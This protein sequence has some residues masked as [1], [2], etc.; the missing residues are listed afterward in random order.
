MTDLSPASLTEDLDLFGPLLLA[1]IERHE[2]RPTAD[3]VRRVR[4][5]SAA[6]GDDDGARAEL[7]D[8]LRA[9]ELD[10]VTVLA[11]ALR[12]FF[13]LANVTE[14]AHRGSDATRSVL[15]DCVDRVVAQVD[16]EIDVRRTAGDLAWRPVL[17]AHPTE[18]SRRTVLTKLRLVAELMARRDAGPATTDDRRLAELVDVL[19]QTDG[20]RIGR[21]GPVDEARTAIYYLDEILVP[22]LVAVADA[23][24]ELLRERGVTVPP[25]TAPI[26]FGTWVGGDRDGNPYVTPEVTETVVRLQS[27]RALVLLIDAV[28]GLSRHLSV[29]SRLAGVSDALQRSLADDRLRFP[30]VFARHER[31]NREEPYRLKCRVIIERLIRTRASMLAGHAAGTTGAVREHDGRYADPGQLLDDLRSMADSLRDNDGGLVADGAVARVMRLVATVGFHLAT[32]DVREHAGRHHAALAAVYAR[33]EPDRAYADLDR[34]GRTE[35]LTDALQ[36]RRFLTGPTTALP[37]DARRTFGVFHAI[38]RVLDR[39][40]DA[41]IE[42]YIVSMTLGVDDLLAP[43]VLAREAGL[44]DLDARLARIGFVPLL[45]T[46]AELADAG[47]LLDRMLSVAPYRR[48]VRLRGDVQEVML[49]YSDSSKL[50]GITTSRFELRRAQ[51]HLRDVARDHGVHLRL[52]HGRGGS[53]GRGGGPLREAIVAQ[54]TGT[55][56]GTIKVTEQGEVISDKYGIPALARRNLELGLAGVL[57]ASTLRHRSHVPPSQVGRFDEVMSI[58][59]DAA[60]RRYRE[61]VERPRFADYFRQ[62]TPVEELGLLP[63][64]SRPARRSSGGGLDELRAIP[65]V[66]GWTQSRQLLPGWFGVGT[67][68]AAAGDA[69]HRDELAW[70]HGRWP[71]LRE[72]LSLVRMTLAKTDLDLAAR[73]V[74]Q[75]VEPELRGVFDE[76]VEEHARTVEQVLAVTGLPSLLADEPLLARTVEVRDR[77]LLPLHELQVSLLARARAATEVDP[78]T[79]R[80]LLL[81]VNGI[82]AGLRNTG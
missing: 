45:E 39:H 4:D 22:E 57:E 47:P 58:A 18:S 42:S 13:D 32:M 64:G 46:P 82:A 43:I 65:W 26:R 60:Y 49:G 15:A 19:W 14:Q 31:L 56:L 7:R 67:G 35:L 50:G 38:R 30:E 3:L 2:G 24:V 5:L 1:S 70:M 27:E 73:Y 75:L 23:Y 52:F 62:S 61:L 29:S 20:L 11:R 16:D 21:P 6:A 37:E 51:R 77:S 53:V 79:Q 25:E 41:A 44:I 59:S 8:G 28:R 54:P 80:A 78:A 48:L 72:F 63:I 71:F 34:A 17:T 36:E 66:F 40:G 33:V 10:D 69:G 12:T 55:V 68:L 76:I 9:L 74:E 81:T